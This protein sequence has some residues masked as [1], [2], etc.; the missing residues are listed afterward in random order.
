MNMSV[1]EVSHLNSES[2][3][4][5][6]QEMLVLQQVTSLASKQL[7]TKIVFR[8]IL[9]LM[10]ELLGLNR[11]RIILLEDNQKFGSI[12]YSYGL[13]KQ[14]VERGRYAIGEGITGSVLQTGQT[15]IVQ[16]IDED[17]NFLG[18]TVKREHLP[19][20]IVS[21]YA[22][23][24][25]VNYI[26][27]GVLACH[28]IRMRRR[29]ISDDLAILKILTTIIS[30][31]LHMHQ[32]IEKQTSVLT[33]QNDWLKKM[34]HSD[35]TRYGIVGK[36]Q[37]VL[38][39]ITMIEQVSQA[40]ASVLLLGESGTG[41]ELFARALHL[42]SP[43]REEP[44]IKVNCAAIPDTLFESE[45]FGY[46]KG[47]FTGAVNMRAGF[48][49]QA[50]GG[51]IFLDE[52]GE[53][54]MQMQTKLLRTLQ[55]GT[56][57]RLGGKSEIKISV[58]V[59]AATNRDLAHEVQ[60]GNFRQD[61]FYRLNVIPIQ[62]PSLAQRRTDIP[63]LAM[64]FLNKTNQNNQKN[65]HL[66]QSALD[67]LQLH[68]WP[69][70]IRELSNFIER[71]VLLTDRTIVDAEE[72]QFFLAQ[73]KSDFLQKPAFHSSTPIKPSYMN[74]P[75]H[76][77]MPQSTDQQFTIRPYAKADSH[78]MEA[79]NCVLQQAGGNKTRAA[80]LLGMT[81]RQFSYRLAKLN[82]QNV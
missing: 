16:N 11:G 33:L 20:E 5:R 62:L 38:K 14:E 27:V 41:K 24:I 75:D 52:I 8:E 43:R 12:K 64:Y 61:L 37:Q 59:V 56:L 39:A 9:H 6:T 19:Q 21:F 22:I 3:Y 26:T 73:S 7:D 50:N 15:I 44:F 40:N 67:Q 32:Y 68:T 77:Y 47:A 1:L 45:L 28:R 36:S 78:D 49:E 4:W 79:L 18:R 31:I 70:N 58:R 72:I 55:E 13:T 35:S 57:T 10:S 74:Q 54:P 30:Q 63:L 17:Q 51:T 42:A 82:E 76:S 34:F 23:P 71:L 2:A 25:Q 66:T 65:V 53:M 29:M 60:L 81:A 80:Q 46:E 69:G 48:F